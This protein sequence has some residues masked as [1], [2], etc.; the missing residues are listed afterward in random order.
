MAERIAKMEMAIISS[1]RVNPELFFIQS[2]SCL[3]TGK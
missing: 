2:A 3:I 1:I